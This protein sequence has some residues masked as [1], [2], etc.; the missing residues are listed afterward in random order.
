MMKRQPRW[1]RYLRAQLRDLRV[2]F[3]ESGKALLL[4]FLILLIGAFLFHTIYLYPETNQHPTFSQALH[5]TFALIFFE[6]VLPFPPDPWYVQFLYFVV[7]VLGLATIAD[8]VL[9]FGTALLNKQSRGQAWQVA[10][11][12]TYK[13]HI[14]VCGVGKIG[15]RVI[16]EL[17]K[18]ERDVV[19]IEMNENG[20]FVEK[21]KSLGIPLIIANARRSENIIKAGVRQADAIIPCTNDELANLDIALD[22]R[23]INPDIKVVMRMFDDDLARRVENGF[24][25]H[26]A[27]SASAVSAPIFAAA[28][29]RV[30]VKHSFYVGDDLLNVSEIIITEQS[31]LVGWTVEKLSLELDLSVIFYQSGELSDMHA[32]PHREL[33]PG[34]KILVLAKMDTLCRVNEMN[35]A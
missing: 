31:Q 34:D 22:A 29:M 25:I 10:M 19:A 5:A 30:N 1:R 14:I 8:G 23:D 32:D 18:F 26:T 2:L 15:Y 13:N 24:G 9:R 12:S 20:R 27:F 3:Q 6:I 35:R 28:A 7:P 33:H 4:F 21:T 16:Q 11:A 17:L